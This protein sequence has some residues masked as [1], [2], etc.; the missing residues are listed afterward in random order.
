MKKMF[1]CISI[2]LLTWN[3]GYSQVTTLWEK[4]AANTTNPVWNTGS[5]VRG[6][7][8]GQVGANHRLFVV[9]R[10]ADYGGKQIIIFNAATGDSVGTL[11][12]TGLAGGTFAVNDVEVSAD[13]K[14]FVC[15]LTTNAS[16]DS[17]RVYR[18]DSEASAPVPVIKYIAP[19]NSR[20]GDKFTVTGSTADNS[21]IIWAASAAN[22]GNLVKFTTTDNGNTFTPEVIDITVFNGSASVGPLPNEDFYY[23]AQGNNVQKYSATGTLMGTVPP[24]IVG[25]GSNAIRF[26]RS[27]VGDEFFTTIAFGAGLEHARIVKVPGGNL[28]D[29]V[30]YGTTVTLG[31][32]NAAGLGD[33]AVRKI[34]DLVF[35]VYPLSTNNGFGAY[36]VTLEAPAL[37]GDYYIGD[38]GTAPGGTDPH[39]IT[40]REAFGIMNEANYTGDCNFFITSNLHEPFPSPAPQGEYGLGLA[41]NPEPF[42]VTFKPH[43]GVQP[44]ISL[45]YPV[46]G[47]SGPSGAMVLGIPSKGNIAWAD[48]KVTRNIVFDGSNTVGGTTRDLTIENMTTSHGNAF[49]MTIVGDVSN[50]MIKNCNIYY[51]AQSVSTSNL[52]RAAVQLR[53]RLENSINWTPTNITLENNHISANFTGVSR[54]AQGI[55]VTALSPTPTTYSS[56]IVMKNN[57]IEGNQRAVALNWSGDTDIFDNEII[58]NQ[59]IDATVANQGIV[60]VNVVAGSEV[61]IYNNVVSSVSSL[62]NGANA[63]NSAISIESNGT[64]NVYNNMIFGFNLTAANPTAFLRGIQVSSGTAAANVYYNTIYMDNIDDIGTGSVAYSGL[65]FSNG[66]NTVKNNIIYSAETDFA[67]YCINRTGTAGTLESNYNNFY[68]VSPTNG[69]VGFWDNAAT[70]TLAAWQTASGQDANSVSK[71]VFFVSA[72]DLHLTGTSNGDF[73]LAGTP[74]AG[75]TTDIDGDTR[76]VQFPYMGC[77][78]ASIPLPV[79]LASF[80]ANVVSG[81]VHLQWITASETNNH[82]FEVQRSSGSEFVTIG[83]VQGAGTTTET[84]SYSF[85]DKNVGNGVN[86][87]RLKQV[88]LDG[89]YSYS[90]VIEVDV[91]V[92]LSFNLYQN[93]PNPFNPATTINYEIA[94]PVNVNLIVY[95]ILGEQ[96]MVLVDNQLR[97]PGVYSVNFDAS[98]LA[99]GTYIYRIQAG[100]FVQTKK[101]IL[102]K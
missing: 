70:Q 93:Y 91:E 46:D 62:S 9:T 98:S 102:A 41:I 96:V 17:F 63:G 84:R 30:L 4:S 79:E 76:H 12:T 19:S 61:N 24:A 2:I 7:A 68:P 20:Y 72:T 42:T 82:G 69:N 59:T 89:S 53:S 75:I 78:E 81:N 49:P 80:S 71:E 52:F 15:N 88:D 23:N 99:S 54:G 6:L 58:L 56:G 39:F 27:V 35:H 60:A 16:T 45:A 31:T 36:V 40:L 26:M 57:V 83:F 67:S 47:T 100:D 65:Y 25:T 3:I 34:S 55:V 10:Y 74:I 87:Y 11:D 43:T 95:S 22:N 86:S 8:Y 90:N 14:I 18:Y 1:L 66:T 51:K 48:L 29:A 5:V 77:D 94:S 64:Y 32:N 44:V 21:I 37:S 38:Y 97:E 50:V 13:G 85:I 33:V 101:M 28:A 92:P 73:D